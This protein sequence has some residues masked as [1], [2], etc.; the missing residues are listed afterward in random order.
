MTEEKEYTKL[1]ELLAA[2]EWLKADDETA[3]LIVKASGKAEYEI[4]VCKSLSKENI[5]KIPCEFFQIIDELW[6]R[7]S[8][9]KF[10]F[11][12]Q[13]EKYLEE[14]SKDTTFAKNEYNIFIALSKLFGWRGKDYDDWVDC[15]KNLYY[16]ELPSG[17]FP[18][19]GITIQAKRATLKFNL[20]F[21]NTGVLNY[22]DKR[23]FDKSIIR[24]IYL[25]HFHNYLCHNQDG[26][27]IIN[28]FFNYLQTCFLNKKNTC[29]YTFGQTQSSI[30][31]L[32][33]EYSKIFIKT[34]EELYNEIYLLNN[35][36]YYT[37]ENK[38]IAQKQILKSIAQRRGQP[39]FRE[40]LQIAYDNCCAITGCDAEQALEAAHIIPY[41]KTEDNDISNGLLLRA[42]IHTLFDLNLIAI[43]PETYKIY[44][45][46]RLGDSSYCDEIKDKYL[47]LPKNE[48]YRPNKNALEWRWKVFNS[49]NESR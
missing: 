29:N 14:I 16:E 39:K 21:G 43:E 45:A 37:P 20:L 25:Y 30:E 5:S 18:R 1:R 26:I 13:V 44:L 48:K 35:E 22:K 47:K 38:E 4:L 3:R 11:T 12:I 32:I 2:K 49:N 10:G 19:W 23:L 7:Y 34:S 9:N 41:C 8:N 6:M 28:S 24:D 42:D 31:S 27:H 40:G 15:T 17:F 36:N 46:R 33:T